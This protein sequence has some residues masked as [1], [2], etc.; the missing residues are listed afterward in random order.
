MKKIVGYEKFVSKKGV[1][2]CAVSVME[3]AQQRQGVECSGLR[4]YAVMIYGDG[5]DV[6][7]NACVGGE[8]C[9]YFGWSKGACMV[10]SPSVVL[11]NTK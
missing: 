1:R 5:V 2:C 11:P 7:T 4:A 9:G 10:Q 8:L 3:E 6:I